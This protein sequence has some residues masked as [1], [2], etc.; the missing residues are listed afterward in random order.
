MS[1]HQTWAANYLRKCAAE[2]DT[3]LVAVGVTY[4]ALEQARAAFESLRGQVCVDAYVRVQIA[5][6]MRRYA[7]SLDVQAQVEQAATIRQLASEADT[8]KTVVKEE[9]KR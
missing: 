3:D 9:E 8:E 5:E 6:A 4:Y 7:S 1:G 2:I